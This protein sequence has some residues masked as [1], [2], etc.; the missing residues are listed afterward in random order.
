MKR[1][2]GLCQPMLAV[3]L[4]I[5]II[6]MMFG[7]A[8]FA[9]DQ[10]P[11]AEDIAKFCK[12]IKPGQAA[13]ME[14]LEE[15]EAQLSDACKA[16]ETKMEGPRAESKEAVSQQA[17]IR[18]ACKNDVARFCSDV[19]SGSGGISACLK[20]HGIELSSPCADAMKTAMGEEEQKKTK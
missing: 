14:C 13:L 3:A 19:T 12:N 16:Y 5:I 15:H 7:P 2:N 20:K 10:N 6:G 1:H 11:C 9:A 17:R 18:Q 4:F 8:A